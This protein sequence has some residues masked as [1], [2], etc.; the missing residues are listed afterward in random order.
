[1]ERSCS[2]GV[3]F[4]SACSRF[5]RAE[6]TGDMEICF[7]VPGEDPRADEVVVPKTQLI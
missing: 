1:M 7:V 4:S 6:V 5:N 2:A 3:Y